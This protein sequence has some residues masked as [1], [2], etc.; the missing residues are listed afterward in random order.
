M[1]RPECAPGHRCPFYR[2]VDR[3]SELYRPGRGQGSNG[4]AVRAVPEPARAQAG[5]AP[6]VKTR[7]PYFRAG[8]ARVCQ[9]H[10]GRAWLVPWALYEYS[11]L[12]P[13]SCVC[14]SGVAPRLARSGRTGAL[15][16]DSVTCQ[17]PRAAV[18]SG[19]WTR[20]CEY[21]RSAG[22]TR[23][24]AAAP[25]AVCKH[26]S[27]ATLFSRD[28]VTSHTH[29]ALDSGESPLEIASVDGFKSANVHMFAR[30]RAHQGA[31]ARRPRSRSRGAGP[32]W[33]TS[34]R[35]RG[36]GERG[37]RGALVP[38]PRPLEYHQV[39]S[40]LVKDESPEALR[41]LGFADEAVGGASEGLA[42]ELVDFPRLHV[43]VR[44]HAAL[45]AEVGR[46]SNVDA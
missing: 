29:V 33:A 25:C 16:S 20:Q 31:A 1:R 11:M 4:S 5:P 30:C 14:L 35:A 17:S 27:E 18:R 39:S 36:L 9:Y 3:T 13:I 2:G 34:R 7:A 46:H 23:R 15:I 32:L 43:R 19:V 10:Q 12:A 21:V 37:Q 28:R 42:H 44:A 6:G 26:V 40:I 24:T 45:H 22:R 38:S 41:R 8:R